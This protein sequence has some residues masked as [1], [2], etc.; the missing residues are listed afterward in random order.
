MQSAKY[1]CK[2]QR[3]RSFTDLDPRSLRIISI[4]HFSKPLGWF[5]PKLYI[6]PQWG[7]EIKVCSW[8]LG[9]VTKMA[10]KPIY[11]KKDLKFY[12]SVVYEC[13]HLEFILKKMLDWLHYLKLFTISLQ[14]YAK[15]TLASKLPWVPASRWNSSRLWKVSCK[16]EFWKYM[17]KVL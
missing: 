7:W 8:S 17:C 2:Y 16:T 13:L 1:F 5:K 6:E 11:G 14:R 9:H 3:S 10:I 12:I 4:K 15:V